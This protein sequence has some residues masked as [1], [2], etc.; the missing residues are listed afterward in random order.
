MKHHQYNLN[1]EFVFPPVN[2]KSIQIAAR[3]N[4][5]NILNNAREIFDEIFPVL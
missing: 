5:L 2:F 3:F 4:R 1:Y